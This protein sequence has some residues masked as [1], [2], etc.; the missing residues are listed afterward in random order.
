MMKPI[1]RI[2]YLKERYKRLY[3]ALVLQIDKYRLKRGGKAGDYFHLKEVSII[4]FVLLMLLLVGC[5]PV[6]VRMKITNKSYSPVYYSRV[7]NTLELYS[8]LTKDTNFHLVGIGDTVVYPIMGNWENRLP[9]D[10]LYFIF[11]NADTLRNIPFDVIK[12]R[13]YYR[14]K[15]KTLGEIKENNWFV[16]YK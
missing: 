12:S 14:I 7:N 6:D 10:T 4:I 11:F 15:S 5:D 16:N 13:K 3:I 9:T 2:G 1:I 8:P